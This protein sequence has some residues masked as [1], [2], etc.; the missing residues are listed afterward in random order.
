MVRSDTSFLCELGFDWNPELR[1]AFCKCVTEINKI[2]SVIEM[3][4]DWED[5]CLV[6][7]SLS[8]FSRKVLHSYVEDIKR[9]IIPSESCDVEINAVLDDNCI[10]FNSDD[11]IMTESVA[12]FIRIFLA[13]AG[14]HEEYVTIEVGFTAG[15]PREGDSG[16]GLW[17]ITSKYVKYETTADIETK[18]AKE[19]RNSLGRK[20]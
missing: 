18:L 8:E 13:E 20:S 1:S 5:I 6:S 10:Y 9:G 2:A 15:E 7:S 17:F 11:S 4:E 19:F 12:H 16:G 3:R 14:L